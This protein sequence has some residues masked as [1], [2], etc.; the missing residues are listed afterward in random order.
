[1]RRKISANGRM[2]IAIYITL[3]AF[4]HLVTRYYMRRYMD[5]GVILYEYE[6]RA[7]AKR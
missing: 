5:K 6:V 4:I 1:V 2:K 7:G 3:F